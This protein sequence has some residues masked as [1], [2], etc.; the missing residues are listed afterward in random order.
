MLVKRKIISAR[1]T[2]YKYYILGLITTYILAG[3]MLILGMILNLYQVIF[4]V[5][6]ILI[7]ASI[8]LIFQRYIL[9]YAQ[10]SRRYRRGA[11]GEERVGNF[12][13]NKMPAGTVVLNDV[14]GLPDMGKVNIDHIVISEHALFVIETKNC[15][16][17]IICNGDEWRI[18]KKIIRSPSKQVKGN[19]YFLSE[20]VTKRYP[21]LSNPWVN[22]IVVFPNKESKV[23]TQEEPERCKIARSCEELLEFIKNHEDIDPKHRTETSENDRCN[24]FKIFEEFDTVDPILIKSKV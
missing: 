9:N 17:N 24:L 18:D 21:I 8:V 12:L 13:K 2:H 4:V 14:K 11:E 6:G 5:Y 16:G 1:K 22:G 10:Q 15:K 7:G 23:F 20:F 3:L 19:A